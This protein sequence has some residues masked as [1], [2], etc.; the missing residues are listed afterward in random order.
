MHAGRV[1]ELQELMRETFAEEAR[2]SQWER[3]FPCLKDPCRYLDKFEM[4]R[5][6]TRDV[7]HALRDSSCHTWLQM[8]AVTVT[9]TSK[10]WR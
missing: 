2:S 6:S 3:V 7:C 4:V 5:S 8:P 1:E 9:D 10:A